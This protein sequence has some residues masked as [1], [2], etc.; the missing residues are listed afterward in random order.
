MSMTIK[1]K[2]QRITDVTYS[3]CYY[4]KDMPDAGFAF[5]CNEQGELV[6]LLMEAGRENLRKCE[7]G[8]YDVTGPTIERHV[9][10]YIQPAI[11][12]CMRCRSPVE[13]CNALTNTCSCGVAYNMSGQ[14]LAEVQRGDFT[15]EDY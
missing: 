12:E 3:R 11:G 15:E 14:R 9:D 4:W 5:D 10:E 13:L 2:R 6:G 7:D 1:V 8:I